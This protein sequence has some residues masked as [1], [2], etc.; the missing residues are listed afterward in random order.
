MDPA[1]EPSGTPPDERIPASDSIMLDNK[2]DD[3]DNAVAG[4]G[5]TRIDMEMAERLT[6][7]SK[8]DEE[9]R[10]RTNTFLDNADIQ[11][12]IADLGNACWV[13]HHFTEEIQTRQYRSLE[14]LLGSGYGPPADIWS[15]A[16]MAFELVTGEFLFEPHSGENYTRD[17]DHIALIVEL[18]GRIPRHIALSGKYSKEYFTK[19]GDLKHIKKLK[20]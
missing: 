1:D 13:D 18:M 9:K 5:E 6:I 15:T 10:T 12:K 14:V 19:K 4:N 17:E 16:C 2:I 8:P 3:S 7:D 11:V 20:P